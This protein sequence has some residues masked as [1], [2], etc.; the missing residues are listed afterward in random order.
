MQD[1]LYVAEG[2]NAHGETTRAVEISLLGVTPREP[3]TFLPDKRGDLA[4]AWQIWIDEWFVPV[5]A[6]KFIEVHQFAGK[7]HL[8]EAAAVDLALDAKLTDTLRERSLKAGALFLEGKSSM[9]HHPEW[10]R[11][12]AKVESGNTPG[13]ALTLA[14][15]QSVLYHLALIPALTSYA[16][17]EFHSGLIGSGIENA[18]DK[19]AVFL[20]IAPHLQLAVPSRTGHN[21]SGD[22]EGFG[23]LRAI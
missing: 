16:W 5:L 20:K 19:T 15:L 12:A 3:A 11:F 6:P 22:D 7:F 4:A 2:L 13:H 9:K 14:A 17:F 21:E 18:E 8:K 1:S 23:Q 10:S